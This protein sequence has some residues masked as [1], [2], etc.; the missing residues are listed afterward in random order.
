MKNLNFEIAK[1]FS[2]LWPIG[3]SPYAPGTIASLFAAFLGYLTNIHYG[4]IFTLLLAI[5]TGILGWCSTKLY[6]ETNNMQLNL[7]SIN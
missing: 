7:F 1:Y 5:F 2:V 3:F 4:S 6:L